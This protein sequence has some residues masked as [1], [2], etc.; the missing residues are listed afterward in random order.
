MLTAGKFPAKLKTY[1]L[2]ESRAGHPM[3]VAI[4]ILK[5]EHGQDH[6]LTWRGSLK[7]GRASELTIDQL[8]ILGLK[9]DDLTGL[10]QG[11]ESG[12]LNTEKEVSVSVEIED[13]KG[14]LLP[15]IAWINRVSGEGF[16]AQMSKDE[17]V[18]KFAGLNLKTIVAQR[19]TEIGN[20]KD[21]E[22][23]F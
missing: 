22:I 17:A 16:K 8:L 23:P 4:F 13:Y 10:A 11:A 1:G 3:V 2:E 5:D 9:G 12:L 15:K 21:D 20:K 7:P 6:N 19:R 14:R 18:K